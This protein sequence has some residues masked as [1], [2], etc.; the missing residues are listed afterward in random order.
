MRVFKCLP[1]VLILLQTVSSL[2]FGARTR[3]AEED[4]SVSATGN[5]QNDDKKATYSS[6]RGA[7]SKVSQSAKEFTESSIVETFFQN[8]S[9]S[10]ISASLKDRIRTMSNTK[11]M[12]EFL[13]ATRRSLHRNPELM[14]E[15]PFT[16]ETIQSILD[17]LGI[18]YT[19]GWAKN[20]HPDVYPG[21]GGY[22][23]VAHIGSG[24]KEKPC[25]IL[26]ADMDALPILEATKGIETF[27]STTPGKMHA[28]GHDGHVTMLLGAAA[29]LKSVEKE[30]EGT[31]R[32]VFQP[33]EEGGA[34]MKRM[35]EEG[36][37]ELEPK[38]LNAFGMHVWPTLPT[39]TVASRPGPLMA[40][41]EMF[42]IVVTGKGGHA[43]MPHLTIDPIVASA[44]FVSN[45]QAIVS[46][47]ISPLESGVVSVTQI[48]A[49]DA[50]NVIPAS[51]TIR[52]TIRA[53]STEMLMSLRDKVSQ[54]LDAT[55][56]THGCHSTIKFSPDFYPPTINDGELFDWS[57]SV[58]A[59]VSREGKTRDIVPTMGGED[60]AFLAQAIPSVFFFIGQGSGGDEKYHIP[61]SDYG[62]HHP[63]FALDE[64]VLPVGVELHA[65]LAL[66][67]L[68]MLSEASD[69]ISTEE[70]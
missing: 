33:A 8:S 45:L 22:G 59:L 68:K 26:R 65:N 35:V 28:C 54:I 13:Q 15:L 17:E 14:Y 61:R 23:I 51:A 57:K 21:A 11:E 66:R 9:D 47:T 52:G 38:A 4:E 25:V 64:E 5:V 32:L 56:L 34:G 70:L 1:H 49:G 3:K 10:E 18:D 43:A 19:T 42:E 58:G 40:A 30:I 29:L 63:S 37:V 16:S 46:R 27:K 55:D 39:G 60:F 44:S 48:S 67:S 53:L 20:T 24:D 36:I 41:A 31:V 2:P 62:L 50:F 7:A 6:V 12:H 69:E